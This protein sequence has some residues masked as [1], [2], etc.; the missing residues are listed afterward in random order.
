MKILEFYQDKRDF[1][2]VSEFLEGGELFDRIE[3]EGN[4][5]EFN[6]ARMMKQVLSAIKY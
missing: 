2:I 4:I 5:S 1:Y 3:A 6:A